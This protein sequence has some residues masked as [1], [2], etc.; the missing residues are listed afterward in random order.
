MNSHADIYKELG[1]KV[2]ISEQYHPE[3]LKESHEI[4]KCLSNKFPFLFIF[5]DFIDPAAKMD[6][7]L[8][9]CL[10]I[11]RNS[12]M[13]SIFSVQGRTL[14]SAV[15]RN[16]INYICVFKQNTPK[17]FEAVIKEF[18]SMWL[19]SGMTMREMIEFT[20]LATEDHQF[21]F[22]DNIKGECYL[23]KLNKEQIESFD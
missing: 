13:N 23:S 17:E 5:D 4:N 14:M 12:N 6:V 9:K 2:V 19:P 8:T 16:N 7:E 10:T 1:K 15:G 18:L 11:Y 3:L 20:K 22:I 21:I